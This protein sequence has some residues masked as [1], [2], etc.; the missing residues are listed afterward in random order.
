M[1]N[2][3]WLELSLLAV[4]LALTLWV[5]V[6]PYFGRPRGSDLRWRTPPS[7][8]LAGDYPTSRELSLI[9]DGVAKQIETVK[10]DQSARL[11]EA[12]RLDAVARSELQ[13]LV[14][15]RLGRVEEKVGDL[16]RSL[17][18]GLN[19]LRVANTAELDK[20]RATNERQLDQMRMT[21]EEKLQGTL[22][23][24]LGE[25]FKLVSDQLEMVQRGLGEMQTLATDVGGLKKVLTNVKNRGTWGEVQLRRQI[26]DVLAPG[27]YEENVAV[28]P[29]TSQRVEYAV[30]LPGREDDAPVMLPIDSKFPLEPY[31]RLLDAQESGESAGAERAAAELERALRIQAQTIAQKYV[32]PPHTTDFAIMYLPTE[33]LFA[34]AIRIPGFANQVQR[35]FSVVVAGPT[36]FA[37]LLSSLH[38]GFKTLAIEQRTSEVWGVLAA[39]KTEFEKYGEVWAKLDRQLKTAQNTVREAGRR[40]R[41]VERQLREVESLEGNSSAD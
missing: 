24:R 7:E 29:G 9:A 19:V 10:A 21:V 8:G 32:Y 2:E 23:K 28:R 14:A 18:E 22:E 13:M 39:A 17:L 38:M 35:E 31:E 1:V 25:S 26:E 20:I 4:I 37:S 5:V 6:R 36:T 11:V 34:E 41:A 33:G 15:D 40:T 30:K 27:Q 12:A 16:D 3:N